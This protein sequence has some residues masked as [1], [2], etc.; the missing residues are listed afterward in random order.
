[1]K[2]ERLHSEQLRK[3]CYEGS[4]KKV[5]DLLDKGA[6]PAPRRF[7]KFEFSIISLKKNLFIKL[8]IRNLFNCFKRFPLKKKL[9]LITVADFG[10]HRKY[11]FFKP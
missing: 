6:D 2:S 4:L 11:L 3:A 7:R 8:N 5:K 10:I 1:M 9:K